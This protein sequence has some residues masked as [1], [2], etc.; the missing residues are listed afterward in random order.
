MNLYLVTATGGISNDNLDLLIKAQTRDF[1]VNAWRKH[2][3]LSDDDTVSD[4]WLINPDAPVGALAWGGA[5]C[6][7]I[8]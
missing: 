5:D 7:V 3:G 6:K 4:V 1:A 8:D 2:Y